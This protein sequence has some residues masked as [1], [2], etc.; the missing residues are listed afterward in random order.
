[1]RAGQLIR[2]DGTLACATSASQPLTVILVNASHP[3]L[4][5]AWHTTT[6]SDGGYT[7]W[8]RPRIS[9]R[10]TT[11]YPGSPTLQSSSASPRELVRLVP[12]IRAHFTARRTRT[13]FVNP[14]AHGSMLPR[15]GA[16]I[17]LTWQARI[18]GGR[19]QLIGPLAATV[20]PKSDG[21]F[22]RQLHVGPLDPH[23]QLRLI[24]LGTA[25]GPYATAA[26]TTQFLR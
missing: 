17:T 18:P 8:L 7:V 12:I 24:Y 3:R 15:H 25:G 16:S 5:H 19:W 6:R 14:V 2:V 23:I 11:G 13:G 20:R 21:T 1:V 9:G 4:T 22:V 10:I 26:S